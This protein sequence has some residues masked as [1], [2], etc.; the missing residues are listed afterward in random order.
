MRLMKKLGV[1]GIFNQYAEIYQ[2]ELGFTELQAYMMLKLSQNVSQDTDLL[3]AE[4]MNLQY[5]KA[6]SAMRQYHDD[7]EKC[8]N[9]KDLGYV[10]YGYSIPMFPY[11]TAANL[12]RWEQSFV[13][14]EQLTK[15]DPV[16]LF[17]VRMT[18]CPLD[19]VVLDKWQKVMKKYPDYFKDAKIFENRVR[20]TYD[21]V[22]ATH[23]SPD[24]AK[25][26]ENYMKRVYAKLDAKIANL[27]SETIVEL[28]PP[29]GKAI[30]AQFA[31]IPKEKIRRVIPKNADSKQYKNISDPDAAF[32]VATKSVS[33][34]PF[35][36]GFYDSYGRKH[37]VQRSVQL[38]E[39][40]AGG[41]QIYKLGT[42][43]LTV[44]CRVWIADWQAGAGLEQFYD[45]GGNN[46]WDVYVSL[47]FEGPMYPGNTS[48]TEN[49]VF[50]DQVIL[51]KT[52]DVKNNCIEERKLRHE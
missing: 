48:A 47:K 43:E 23:V 10:G 9:G 19:L 42:V 46:K 36:M 24:R 51:I 2:Y 37:G 39:I 11:L 18:R 26:S 14:M 22:L 45:E 4:F 30:P 1:Q 52:D 15:D 40:K 20:S 8:R 28:E 34:N 3:I 50:I 6:A 44:A 17:N 21:R 49:R 7:L 13:E 12:L 25:R 27:A 16:R 29:G 33:M 32:G 31:A 38:S 41:Y 35:P 5:G